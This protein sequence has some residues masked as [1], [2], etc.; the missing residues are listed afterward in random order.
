MSKQQSFTL[1]EL[2]VVI[3][4]I[5]ILAGVIMIST[6]SSIDK[7]SITKL[8]AFSET[9]KN[10]MMMNLVSEFNFD[11][12][13]GASAKDTWSSNFTGPLVGFDV[14]TTAG[15][16]DTHAYGWMSE[17]NCISGTCLKFD[18]AQYINQM[19]NY[20]AIGDNSFTWEFWGETGNEVDG[21]DHSIAYL[22]VSGITNWQGTFDYPYYTSDK[23]LFYIRNSCYRYSSSNIIDD[24]WHHVVGVFN[25]SKTIPD[26]YID[27]VLDNGS[28]AN[29]ECST[30]GSISSGNLYLATNSFKG[31]IDEIKM[32]NEALTLAQIQYNYIAGLNSLLSRG[33]ITQV[34]YKDRIEFLSLK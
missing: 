29:T 17:N 9:I 22:S 1:I 26:M 14:N 11:E 23:A 7:A 3:V 12:G 5:G 34:D 6:S 25:R 31:V 20:P 24:K 8:K 27:G 2:L 32:Y 16:G 28:Y 33:L 19:T 18:T 15:Y 21:Y 30:V 13:S 4:I 10:S